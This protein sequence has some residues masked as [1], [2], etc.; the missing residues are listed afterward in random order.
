[1]AATDL[2]PDHEELLRH[3]HDIDERVSKLR[4]EKELREKQRQGLEFAARQREPPRR[5]MYDDD[6][7]AMRALVPG[8]GAHSPG[9]PAHARAGQGRSFASCK[10]SRSVR[11]DREVDPVVKY[12][13]TI[14]WPSSYSP[15]LLPQGETQGRS[16]A[17]PPERL[18]GKPVPSAHDVDYTGGR[19]D[20]PAPDAYSPR[21]IDKREP[22][23]F[24]M[25][26]SSAR[27]M[28]EQVILE[29]AETPGPGAYDS[30]CVL[31][32]SVS[33]GRSVRFSQSVVPSVIDRAMQHGRAVPG[34]GA[35]EEM[36]H[37]PSGG[38]PRFVKG[39]QVL[40]MI[41]RVQADARTKPGPAEYFP[42]PSFG[43]ER[44]R[45]RLLRAAYMETISNVQSARQ[46][47]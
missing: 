18:R 1:M 4:L 12:A 25:V 9:M 23:S 27:T 21:P 16:F 41:D 28:L 5:K 43:A 17:L 32:A 46:R 47:Q 44:E 31:K 24:K 42:T 38:S 13:G 14:P 22:R 35:Y 10:Y 36:L 40:S 30:A 45:Q 20:L 11:Y 7:M 33:P 39:G 26:P 15:E 37:S 19:R 3:V 34:P 2:R 29:A 8:P 6:M